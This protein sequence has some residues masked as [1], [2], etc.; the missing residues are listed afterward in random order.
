MES[1]TKIRKAESLEAVHTHTHTHTLCLQNGENEKKLNKSYNIKTVAYILLCVKNITGKMTNSLYI[2]YEKI[3]V[4]MLEVK[5]TK[6]KS[7][8]L[9]DTS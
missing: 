5:F 7:K 2:I 3:K 4:G 6:L 1:K 9:R 8:I